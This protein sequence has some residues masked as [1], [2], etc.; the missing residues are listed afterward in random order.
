MTSPPETPGSPINRLMRSLSGKHLPSLAKPASTP[1]QDPLPVAEE[2][3][4]TP[5]AV[6]TETVTEVSREVP[7]EEPTPAAETSPTAG[8]DK[9][10]PFDRLKA[11][12]KKA[13][14]L[15]PAEALDTAAPVPIKDG[16]ADDYDDPPTL[17]ERIRALI[18]SLPSPT[19][20]S[21]RT[22]PKFPKATPIPR[23]GNGRPIPPPGAIPI[24][25][26]RLIKRLFNPVIMNAENRSGD[27]I[28]SILSNYRHDDTEAG[29]SGDGGHDTDS[30][31]SGG[32]R[33]FSDNS[34]IMMYSP[35]IPKKDDLVEIADSEVVPA[36]STTSLQLPID[37]AIELPPQAF[38]WPW[39]KKR[40]I[41]A[42]P[43]CGGDKKDGNT[44]PDETPTPTPSLHPI[45]H[46][47]WIPSTTKLSCEITWWGYRL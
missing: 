19:P 27:S 46:R 10:H 44:K 15:L 7:A 42:A 34:S 13:T 22:L 38:K 29:P 11:K 33:A 32:S 1:A 23:D 21:S 14:L 31:H 2:I 5:E 25:D 18:D 3:L 20:R 26:Q 4:E 47:V 8:A 28:W 6:A 37:H 36:P 41:A 35:L 17:A 45:E 9:F 43:A 12:F 40:E 39:S 16:D 30:T 24:K